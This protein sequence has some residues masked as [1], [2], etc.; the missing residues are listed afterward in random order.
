MEIIE[1]NVLFI[2][3]YYIIFDY[4]NSSILSGNYHAILIVMK[5]N[6]VNV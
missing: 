6:N 4:N 5:W 2:I 1:L 3:E